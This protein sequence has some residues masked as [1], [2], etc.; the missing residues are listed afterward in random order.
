M[1]K[2]I[3]LL[4]TVLLVL[5]AL[6]LCASAQEE[7]FGFAVASDLHYNPPRA[8]LEHDIDD[9]VFWYANRRAAMEAEALRE[10]DFDRFLTLVNE[11]GLSSV[12]DLENIW[13]PAHPDRQ[14]VS[15]ALSI[16]RELLGNCGAIRV[17]GGGFAGTV[18]AFVPETLLEP[19]R[20]GI[21]SVFGEGK[22]HILHIRPIGGCVLNQIK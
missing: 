6:P 19:F 10:G 14:A 22:C 9:P 7:G 20:S 15:L 12:C 8:E 16:G 17:H 5:T 18:Q 13:S 11:S 1:K 3:A 4:L 21:E 2:T